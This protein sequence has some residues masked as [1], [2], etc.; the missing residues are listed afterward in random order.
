VEE[1]LL[2]SLGARDAAGPHA[3]NFKTALRCGLRHSTNGVIVKRGV[4]NDSA[5][6]D[7]VFFQLE[8]RLNQNKEIGSV[9]DDGDDGG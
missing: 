6:S 1:K 2:I 8:L 4:T 9:A 7:F 3:E 5:F